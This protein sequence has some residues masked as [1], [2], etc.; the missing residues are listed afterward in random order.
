M[1]ISETYW[2]NYIG[3][4]DDTMTLIEHLIGKHK[5]EITDLAALLLEYKVNGS[6]DLQE[7]SGDADVSGRIRITATLDEHAL[8]NQALMDFVAEPLAFDLSEM[9]TEENIL[10]MVTI[11]E[12]LRKVL[13]E[14]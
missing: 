8:M 2:E 6:I 11:C 3:D 7:L 10:E 12:A 1:Y 9:M 4:T 5:E 13:Y 14:E